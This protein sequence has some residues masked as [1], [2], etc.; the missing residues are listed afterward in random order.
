MSRKEK[1]IW[2][3]LAVAA[4]LALLALAR[5]VGAAGAPSMSKGGAEACLSLARGP[6]KA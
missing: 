2:T 4:A 5:E 6:G 1:W 3:A